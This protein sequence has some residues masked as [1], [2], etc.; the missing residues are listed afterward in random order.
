LGG[1]LAA[2]DVVARHYRGVYRYLARVTG[3]RDRAEDL[4]QE[5]FLRVTRA[6]RN[7]DHVEHERG[8]VFA[9]ARSVV[10]AD[11]RS[12]D[13]ARSVSTSG[14]AATSGN[15]AL[16]AELSEAL[17]RLPA[18]DRDVILLREVS[19]L[20]YAEIAQACD[21]TMESVRARLRRTRIALRDMLSR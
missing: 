15:Q 14:D 6:A 16:V 11:H 2:E 21:C 20:T 10:A 17:G 19:G 13:P 8:W 4:T 18:V 5:V 3:S 12:A 7:G 1:G 9:V